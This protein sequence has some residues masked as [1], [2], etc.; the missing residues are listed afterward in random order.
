LRLRTTPSGTTLVEK[1]ATPAEK[2]EEK[3][4]DKA[5][6]VDAKK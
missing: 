5:A 1:S 4:A 2:K 6:A 3:A